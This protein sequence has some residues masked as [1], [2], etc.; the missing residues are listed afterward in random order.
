M[1]LRHLRY[2]AALSEHLSF[3]RAADKV[4]ITQSTLSHQ[5]KQLEDEIGLRLFD[6]IGKRIVITEAGEILLEH[7]SKALQEIDEGFRAMKGAADP[8]GGTVHIGATHT[9]NMSLVP[10]CIAVFRESQPSIC[11]EVRELPSG[12]IERDLMSE[13]LEL[14]IA[15]YPSNQ[16]ELFFEPLYIDD[17]VLVVA[18]DHPLASRPHVRLAE[19]HRHELVLSSKESSTRQMLDHRFQ[20]VGAEPI[21]V[22]EMN[23]VSGMLS[24]VRR[25]KIAAIVSKLATAEGDGLCVIPLENPKPLRTPGL[26]WKVKKPQSAMIKAFASTIRH[27][28]ADAKM[29]PPR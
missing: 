27:V 11:V 17:M 2:F 19:L 25:T 3:T 9:F 20:S 16:Q 18:P 5:I 7:V 28:V 4:H 29:K 14:G 1:E 23:S 6:R 26:L 15:Y 21:V 24:L 8:L 12:A 10:T 13:E 22:A